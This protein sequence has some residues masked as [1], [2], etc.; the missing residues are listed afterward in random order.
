MSSKRLIIPNDANDFIVAELKERLGQGIT[1]TIAFGG[2]SMLPL[3]DGESDRVELAP[4]T[5]E[6]K[7]GDV[8]LFVYQGRCVVHRLLKIDAERL[9]FRGDNCRRHE[10][11]ERKDV[12]A[13]LVA[14]DHS[15][16]SRVSCDSPQW[17]LRSRCVMLRRTLLNL[18][19]RLFGRRQ[20]RWERWVYL[21]L[22]LVLMWA[23]I[24]GLGIQLD[25]F[26]LGIRLDHLLHASV[27]V[28]FV[29]FMMDLPV[30]PMRRWV[31]HWIM[32][33]L[34]AAVTETGQLA[35]FYRG[36]DPNDLI[37]NSLGVTLGWILVLMWKRRR[38]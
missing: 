15:D 35:L 3:I 37:A 2:N 16:G 25:N 26:V 14:I 32:G 18:P 9:V 12:L 13:R 1:V 33:L 11:V 7:R 27:Y 4:L 22:L 31:P 19:S 30:G 38:R 17:R 36:F 8:Y 6:M 21:C 34:F 10:V 5:G 29:F 20:R 28:P 24:G 23:P